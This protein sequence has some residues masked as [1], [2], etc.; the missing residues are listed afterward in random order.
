MSWISRRNLQDFTDGLRNR[1]DDLNIF[2]TVSV[3]GQ[4]YAAEGNTDILPLIAGDNLDISITN[5]GIEFDSP[6]TITGWVGSST[7]WEALS[8]AEKAKYKVVI[9]NND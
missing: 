7:E 6:Y 8:S 1:I 3:G 2:G 9:F 5:N 4:A